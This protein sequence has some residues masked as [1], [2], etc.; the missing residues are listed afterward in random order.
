[1]KRGQALV[2][3]AIGSLVFIT[4]LLFGIHFAEH[5]VVSMKLK[6]AAAFAAF[7]VTARQV[8][9]FGLGELNTGNT[10]ATFDPP[11]WGAQSQDRYKDFDGLSDSSGATQSIQAMTRAENFGLS[12]RADPLLYFGLSPAVSPYRPGPNGLAF[13]W[14]A[15]RFRG[16]GGASCTARATV[17]A[18]RIPT[19]WLDQ[20]AQGFFIEQHH[21]IIDLPVCGAGRPSNGACPGSLAVL[22]GDWA[23]DDRPGRPLNE[24]VR[25]VE[26]GVIANP[27]Y[28]EMIERLFVLNGDTLSNAPNSPGRNL[29]RIGAGMNGSEPEWFDETLFQMSFKGDGA[30]PA[31]QIRRVD[32][33]SASTD[34]I[35]DL[36]YQTSGAHLRSS[37]VQW[38]EWTGDINGVPRCFL[39]LKGC[40]ASP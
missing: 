11:A 1:M 25:S 32:M 30:G 9:H 18:F 31:T 14:L 3:L 2:E 4:V 39:G 20:G 5:A 19:R 33:F 16:G 28:K 15:G 40:Q 27:A 17:T 6:E 21:N 10:F 13:A 29:L 38:D 22:A 12:C 35:S 8:H 34:G 37:Y 7:D 23:F 24:D 26:R 36:D